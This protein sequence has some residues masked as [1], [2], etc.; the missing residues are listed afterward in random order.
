MANLARIGSPIRQQHSLP[1]ILQIQQYCKTLSSF[2]IQVG[3]AR[4]NLVVLQHGFLHCFIAT[5]KPC[6]YN[7]ELLDGSHI[8][9]E[10]TYC[11]SK[12]RRNEPPS[13]K[14]GGM[15]SPNSVTQTSPKSLEEEQKQ[16]EGI[17]LMQG[18]QRSEKAELLADHPQS[19]H[20]CQ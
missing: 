7:K 17:R 11:I 8:P 15:W 19:V 14:A 1:V 16:T 6:V 2:N 20:D 13:N 18:P 3:N 9:L 4:L 10:S 5:T 12:R